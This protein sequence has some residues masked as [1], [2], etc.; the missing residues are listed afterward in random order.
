MRPTGLALIIVDVQRD[1]CPGGALAVKDGDKTVPRLNKVIGAAEAAGLPV[2][3]TRDWHPPSHISFKSQGG[4]WPSHCVQGTPGAEFHSDLL[5][6][7]SATVISKGDKPR[8]EAYSGFQGTALARLLRSKGVDEVFVGGL[9]TDYCVKETALD[10]LREGF[11]VDVMTDC[12][13]AVNLRPGDGARALRTVKT[14]GA[15]LTTSSAAIKRLAGAQHC[16]H[17]PDLSG[18]S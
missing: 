13:R 3:F 5:I 7:R 15:E 12:V 16:S 8:K 10:A 4:V 14:K 9:A 2:Y 18:Q 17:H 11:N 6:P 1:F